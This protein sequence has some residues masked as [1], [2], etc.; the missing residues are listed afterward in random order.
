MWSF[1]FQTKGEFPWSCKTPL[2]FRQPTGP[3]LAWL[4]V[5]NPSW[6]VSFLPSNWNWSALVAL[7]TFYELKEFSTVLFPVAE[8]IS[9]L[10]SRYVIIALINWDRS[11]YINATIHNKIP[12]NFPC[13]CIFCIENYISHRVRWRPWQCTFA[14]PLPPPTEDF[15]L[16]LTTFFHPPLS[17]AHVLRLRFPSTEVITFYDAV[18]RRSG[19]GSVDD[20]DDYLY[21]RQWSTWIHLTDWF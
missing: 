11:D 20:S 21:E 8:Q 1:F 17:F 14:D 4:R 10:T 16:T 18:R 2:C 3:S 19:T 6:H 12:L 13:C 7:S 9:R 15:S 5:Q